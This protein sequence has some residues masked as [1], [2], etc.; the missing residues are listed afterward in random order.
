M[1]APRRPLP[2]SQLKSR[3][4]PAP[5][6]RTLTAEGH[7]RAVFRR[8]IDRGNLI[9]AETVAREMGKLTLG[10]ALELTALIAFTDSRRHGRAGARSLRRYL[11][12]NESAGLDDVVFVAGSLSALGGRDHQAGITAFRAMFERAT[13]RP[14]RP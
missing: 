4:R 14:C 11:E 2:R 3:C 13:R 7:P 1:F 9:V 8:A 10:E 5:G 12:G 6:R